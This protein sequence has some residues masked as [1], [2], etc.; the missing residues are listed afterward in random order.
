M[1]KLVIEDFDKQMQELRD[2]R[3]QGGR[4]QDVARQRRAMLPRLSSLPKGK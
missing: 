1:P 2:R 4:L 3:K